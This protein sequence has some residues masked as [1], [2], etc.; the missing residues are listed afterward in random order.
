ME[1]GFLENLYHP[2]LNRSAA[3]AQK[4]KRT[5]A[6]VVSK[7]VGAL[8]SFTPFSAEPDPRVQQGNDDVNNDV[9][10]EEHDPYYHNDGC[11]AV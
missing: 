6:T 4:L 2:F 1:R 5:A 9:Y 8:I 3:R 11:D 7:S 10:N